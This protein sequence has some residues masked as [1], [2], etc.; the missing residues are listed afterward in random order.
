MDTNG[1]LPNF[2][3]VAVHDC[4]KAYWR[5]P[6]AKHAICGVH[7]LRELAGV[8]EN[9]PLQSWARNFRDML[10]ELD[11][12]KKSYSECGRDSLDACYLDYYSLEYDRIIELG[13][14][15]TPP[16]VKG[17][18]RGRKKKGRVLA[19]VD[20][21]AGLKDSMLLFS[22]DFQVPF[23]NNAAEQS[24]RN[25]KTKMKFF[26][27][28]RSDEG[29]SWYLKIRSF[30]DSARKHGINAFEAVKL[31]FAGSLAYCLSC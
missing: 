2:T 19:L 23:T 15:E 27:C 16:P 1:V 4:W 12:L 29:A 13:K 7:I 21:L 11:R 5:Y 28:F 6:E 8:I 26:G 10:N 31:A 9:N 14:R 22:R 17:Q 24:L 20:R 3:G 25:L 18:K 30:I